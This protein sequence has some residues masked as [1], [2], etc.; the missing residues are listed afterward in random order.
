MSDIK[1]TYLKKTLGI[2]NEDTSI[3]KKSNWANKETF[4]INQIKKA[5]NDYS[6][7]KNV[8]SIIEYSFEL[9]A[10]NDFY[11]QYNELKDI[12][13]ESP[14]DFLLHKKYNVIVPKNNDNFYITKFEEY[15][16]KE[17]CNIFDFAKQQFSTNKPVETI[18]PSETVKPVE[19]VESTKSDEIVKVVD[20]VETPKPVESK[21]I[22]L[23]LKI[24]WV[25]CKLLTVKKN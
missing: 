11:K 13:N 9:A 14:E 12:I 7:T 20:F 2:K 15:K 23:N 21:K 25:T 8:Q 18:K 17:I 6:D 22:S 5:V 3:V 1:T 4:L 19:I 10:Y 24:Y 16:K